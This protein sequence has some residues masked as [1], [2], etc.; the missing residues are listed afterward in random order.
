MWFSPAKSI[1]SSFNEGDEV[2]VE[3]NCH[4]SI[5]NAIILRKLK[6]VYIDAVIDKT[7]GIFLPP[8]EEEIVKALKNATNPKG[9]ILT[10]PNYFG[11][12]YELDEIIEKLR[13]KGLKIIIDSAHG[14]KSYTRS[15]FI[16]K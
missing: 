5:Y 16:S 2:L 1:F 4:K 6:V 13:E 3:R 8:R 11:V 7:L 14:A 12:Y 9:I 10:N 15:I